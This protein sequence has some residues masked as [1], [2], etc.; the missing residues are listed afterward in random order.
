MDTQEAH[1]YHVATSAECE[2]LLPIYVLAKGENEAHKAGIEMVWMVCDQTNT[3]ENGTAVDTVNSRYFT[4]EV[5]QDTG[6]GKFDVIPTSDW[7]PCED[8]EG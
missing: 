7:L 5:V 3:V 1:T 4:F 6:S 2:K 8:P